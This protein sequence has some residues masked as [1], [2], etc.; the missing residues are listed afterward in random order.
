MTTGQ[1]GSASTP[2]LVVRIGAQSHPLRADNGV[3]IIGRDP[4]ATVRV[5]DGRI[6]RSHVRL[7]PRHD[8]WQVIDT[9]TN[10]MFVDGV[11]RNSALITSPMTI[12]LGDADGIPVTLVPGG[13]RDQTVRTTV[14]LETDDLEDNDNWDEL[15]ETDP[16]VARA[17]R[18]VAAR[19]REL[20]IT[21]RSLARDKIIN[22]GTLIAFEKGRSWPRRGTLAK[23]EEVLNWPAGTITRIRNGSPV[24]VGNEVTEVLTDTVQ[25]P[26]MA[27]A[28]ELAMHSIGTAVSAL[29]DPSDPGFTQQATP[30]LANLRQLET[31]A[32]NA[33]R[34]AR[35]TPSV[36]LALSAVR[37]RYNEL[38][39]RAAKSPSATLGQRVYGARHSAELS[40][41]EAANAA[42]VSTET[43][44][45]AEAERSV[46]P[47]AVAAINTLIAQL[48]MS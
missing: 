4:S 37:R 12:H 48:A 27:E 30:I 21:Q 3:A 36:V 2:D 9:S 22:A 44:L 32:A 42:G 46:P 14:E 16:D 5:N 41:E 35:G 47:D 38:M 39:L 1:S 34:N 17:G 23:L 8:G 11:R 31:V 33:A 40:V 29:P 26:L 45:D 6:S 13:P 10:G 19:R 15:G 43:L 18:A 25:A 20:D 7:E 28:V 24:A